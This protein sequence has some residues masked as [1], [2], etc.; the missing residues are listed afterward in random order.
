[1]A[2]TRWFAKR[3]W[4]VILAAPRADAVP[5]SGDLVEHVEF[6]LP[7][8]A[9]DIRAMARAGRSLRKMLAGENPVVVHAH[10]L[11]SFAACLLA[12]QR[13]YVTVHGFGHVPSDPPGYHALRGFGLL[14]AARMAREAFSA[15][16]EL[17][18]PWTF[19]PHASPALQHLSLM[20]L[21]SN[22][23]PVFA[24]IGRLAEPKRPDLFIQALAEVARSV[25]VRGVVAGDGPLRTGLEALAERVRAPVDFLGHVDDIGAVIA[26]AWGVVLI[27]R[28]EA[29]SFAVQEAMWAGRPA[30]ASDLP[31]LRWLVGE[32][33]YLIR[34]LHDVEH[35]MLSLAD[36]STADTLGR[37]AAVRVRRLISPESPFPYL[38]RR[39]SAAV[40]GNRLW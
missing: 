39:F 5:V 22:G 29:L 27:S 21:P 1:M 9:R 36:R 38:E 3:G 34:T 4:R 8:S 18:T 15:T 2:E 7:S 33:G 25:P 6:P 32:T 16:P 31:S 30:I 24:W 26:E 40:S 11:R 13:P 12:G 28:Y 17:A 35:A 23:A 10:G 37:G 14:A 19:L 20:E